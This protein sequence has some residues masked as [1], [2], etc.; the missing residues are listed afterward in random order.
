[1][2]SLSKMLSILDLFTV[3]TP[4]WSAEG[5]STEIGCSAPTGYRYVRELVNAGILLR[6]GTGSYSLGPRIITL[7]YQLRTT[8][9]YYAAGQSLMKALS[10]QTGCDCVMTRLFDNEIIDTHRESGA[11]GL[12]LAYGRGRSRPLF[13]GAAPKVILATQ[14]KAKLRRLYESHKQELA[15]FPLSETWEVFWQT[16]Q[17]VRKD[18]FY[19]SSGELESDVGAIAVP[20]FGE[21]PYAVGSLA[22][23]IPVRRIEFMNHDKLLELLTATADELGKVLR[24]AD[25]HLMPPKES[26]KY[27]NKIINII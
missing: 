22:L 2:S 11:D 27:H 12:H 8:D 1:M 24:N 23:V 15:G 17:K 18:G 19:L 13:L 26:N 6:L 7:D 9:P 25:R 14:P 21:G 4:I 3:D 10:A 16:L 5:I 20:F